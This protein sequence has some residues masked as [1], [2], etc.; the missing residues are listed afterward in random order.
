MLRLGLINLDN[1]K[2]PTPLAVPLLEAQVALRRRS[3][4]WRRPPRRRPGLMLRPGGPTQPGHAPKGRRPSCRHA[5]ERLSRG[6]RGRGPYEDVR[7]QANQLLRQRSRPIG[8]AASPPKVRPHIAPIRPTQV[9]KRSRQRIKLRLCHRI[10]L[11]E[12]NEDTD[13]PYALRRLCPRQERPRRH[14]KPRDELPPFH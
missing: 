7:L 13:P 10:V 2:P 14:A 4:S 3:T 11:V 5:R 12:R 9:R 8:V 6:R 1:S